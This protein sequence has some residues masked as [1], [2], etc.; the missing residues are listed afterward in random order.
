VRG[1]IAKVETDSKANEYGINDDIDPTI[2]TDIHEK[3]KS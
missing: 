1:V 3:L 2:F